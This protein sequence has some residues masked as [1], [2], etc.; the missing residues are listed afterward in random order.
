MIVL[1]GGTSERYCSLED[2]ALMKGVSEKKEK[3]KKKKK[4]GISVLIKEALERSV[5]LPPCEG[6]VE[7]R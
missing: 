1:G 7:K 3:K 2:R 5:A 6:T 4:K